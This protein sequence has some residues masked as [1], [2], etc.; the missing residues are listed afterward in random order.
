MQL[1]WQG[2]RRKGGAGFGDEKRRWDGRRE[3][4]VKDEK[5]QICTNLD[6]V[7]DRRQE[8]KGLGRRNRR[9]V[10]GKVNDLVLGLPSQYQTLYGYYSIT[11][12]VYCMV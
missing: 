5:N 7:D 12:L 4:E 8:E 2:K 9:R 1:A 10:E 3:E 6:L 11:V